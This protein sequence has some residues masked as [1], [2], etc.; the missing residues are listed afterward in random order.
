MISPPPGIRR[1][2]YNGAPAVS[3]SRLQ[4]AKAMLTGVASP[5]RPRPEVGR[6][7]PRGQVP[8]YTLRRDARGPRVARAARPARLPL[9]EKLLRVL[10][11]REDAALLFQVRVLAFGPVM[12]LVVVRDLADVDDREQHED[13]GLHERDEDAEG[14]DERGQDPAHEAE[15][16]AENLLVAEEVAEQAYAERERAHEVADQLDGEHQDGEPRYRPREVPQVSAEPVLP[17]AYR[18]V[19]D[20]RG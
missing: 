11:Q 3:A 1:P 19:V 16:G 6:A 7:G 12:L 5:A 2:S 9:K 15:D 14:H 13:E 8:T 20:E 17:D 18:V 4:N 10:G